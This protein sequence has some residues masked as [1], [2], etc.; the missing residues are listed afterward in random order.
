MFDG[1]VGGFVRANPTG[2]DSLCISNVGALSG[3]PRDFGPLRLTDAFAYANSPG[4]RAM[5]IPSP[6]GV[7]LT[8]S[9]FAP[10]IADDHVAQ[11]IAR[12]GE[13]LAV[14]SGARSHP[15]EH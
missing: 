10:L 13:R 8:F 11:I 2:G 4:L 15:M 7:Q 9:Y 3:R 1:G 14:F 6:R 12:V 5:V